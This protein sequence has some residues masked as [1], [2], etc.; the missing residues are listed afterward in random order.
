MRVR[1]HAMRRNKKAIIV[2]VLSLALCGCAAKQPAAPISETRLLLDTVC[3]ITM[4][5]PYDRE[6][7]SEALDLCQEY[8]ILFSRTVEGSDVWRINNTGGTLVAIHPETA[9]LIGLGLEYCALS[10]GLFDITIGRLSSLWDFGGNAAEVPA[11]S[12]IEE[13]IKTIDY[14]QI[15]IAGNTVQLGDPE[16]MLDLGGIA[17]GYIAEKLAGFLKEKGVKGAVID[18]GGNIV[19]VGTKPDGSAWNIGVEKPFGD[20]GETIGIIS[21]GEASIVT[22]GIYERQFI[23]DGKLYHHILD[24]TTGMPAKS[25]VTSATVITENSAIGDAF[26]TIPVLVGKE[27][28]MTLTDKVPGLK[29]IILILENGEIFQQGDIDFR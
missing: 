22:S 4:Y 17:K 28:T 2:I 9:E 12:D 29:G 16:A 23:K 21:T 7:L 20:S 27:K 24:P 11:L 14:R 10:G 19:T 3:T 26:S 1:N 5:E 25:D 13:A 18:L 15:R 6:L 8:E